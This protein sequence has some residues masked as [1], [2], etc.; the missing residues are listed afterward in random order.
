M[1][2]S[3]PLI[4]LLFR[5]L[6]SQQGDVRC[7]PVRFAPRVPTH[8]LVSLFYCWWVYFF[9]AV[10]VYRGDEV[11]SSCSCQLIFPYCK[12]RHLFTE[13]SSVQRHRKWCKLWLVNFFWRWCWCGASVKQQ[14]PPVSIRASI[15]S[16]EKKHRGL[17]AKP[18]TSLLNRMF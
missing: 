16:L 10:L 13:T 5:M 3:L 9:Q 2:F 17:T 18:S 15:S 6:M 7:S 12:A 1:C 8:T 11:V 4:D 14:T